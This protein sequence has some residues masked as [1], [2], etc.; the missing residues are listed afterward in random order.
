MNGNGDRPKYLDL[1]DPTALG[2][3]GR[4]YAY[5]LALNG[6]DGARAVLRNLKA[7]FE[8]IMALAGCAGP[9]QI[10][11]EQVVLEP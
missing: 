1:L 10:G 7:D 3:I 5:G 11:R 2:K 8:L 6:E 4:P 9:E